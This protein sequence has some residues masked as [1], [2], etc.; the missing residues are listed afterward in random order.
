MK[1]SLETLQ[2]LQKA[3]DSAKDEL[4]NARNTR[5][6]AKAE[7]RKNNSRANRKTAGKAQIALD[8]AQKQYEDAADKVAAEVGRVAASEIQDYSFPHKKRTL[9][10]AKVR[11]AKVRKA[12]RHPAP[13]KEPIIPA[14]AME[15]FGNFDW[16]THKNRVRQQKAAERAHE[17]REMFEA[18][19]KAFEPK[20]TDDEQYIIDLCW[21][22]IEA[23]NDNAYAVLRDVIKKDVTPDNA[24]PADVDPGLYK[25]E[26]K[27]IAKIEKQLDELNYRYERVAARLKKAEEQEVISKKKAAV[28]KGLA[29]KALR[30][31]MAATA[32][33]K[34]AAYV[35]M[36]ERKREAE[37]A[38][39]T[40]EKWLNEL[41]DARKTEVAC[42]DWYIAK[43]E[44]LKEQLEH[45][46][47]LLEIAK[48]ARAHQ[49]RQEALEEAFCQR[50]ERAEYVPEKEEASRYKMYS[51]PPKCLFDEEIAIIDEMWKLVEEH[52]AGW[53]QMGKMLYN[54][55][56]ALIKSKSGKFSVDVRNCTINN[57]SASQ[58]SDLMGVEYGAKVPCREMVKL[59]YDVANVFRVFWKFMGNSQEEADHKLHNLR[60]YVLERL[61]KYGCELTDGAELFGIFDL[62]AANNTMQKQGCCHMGEHE[63]MKRTEQLREFGWVLKEA[64]EHRTDNASEW[65]KR[66]AI[67]TTP[68]KIIKIPTVDKDGNQAFR[69]TNVQRI[70]MVKN[71]DIERWCNNV[72]TIDG[73]ALTTAQ[74][75]KLKMT[76]FDGQAVWLVPNAPTTQGRGPALKY[77][78]VAMPDYKLPEFAIDIMGNKVRVAD[79]DILMTESCWKANKMGWNWYQ[80]RDKMTELAKECEGFD[81]LRAVRYSDREI[82]DEENPRNLARQATQQIVHL[83]EGEEVK[84]TARTRK[85]LKN[86]KKYWHI[87]AE[88]GEL[89]KPVNERSSLALLFNRFPELVMHP[90]I[91][92][93]LRNSWNAKKNKACSGRLRTKGVYPYICMDPIAQIQICLEGRDP[94]DKDLGVLPEGFVNLPKVKE[95]RKM[96]CLRYP[97]NYLVGMVVRQMNCPEFRGL[98]NIAVLPYYGDIIVRADGDFDGDEMLF[99]F[100]LLMI[101]MMERTIEEFKPC[102]IDF[103]HGKVACDTPFGTEE[104]FA[105]EIAEALVRAQEFNLVGRYSNLAVICLQQASL[106]TDPLVKAKWLN[107]AK[108]AHVGAIVC[109]DMV[110]G[111]DVPEEL[112]NLLANLNKKIRAM[113]KMPWN[114]I[115]SH[116]E[117][118]EEDVEPRT[119]ST[120]DRIAGCICDDVGEFFVDFEDDAPVTCGDDI[121]MALVP[122]G[123]DI[124]SVKRFVVDDEDLARIRGCHFEDGVDMA[125]W[126]KLTNGEPIGWKEW[127]ELGWHNASSLLWKMKGADMSEKRKELYAYV[128][129]VLM[130][131]VTENVWLNKDGRECTLVEKY[132]SLITA[133]VESAFEYRVKDGKVVTEYLDKNGT[134]RKYGNNIA[135]DMKGSYAMFILRVFAKDILALVDMGVI[136][137]EAVRSMCYVNED[138]DDRM[139]AFWDEVDDYVVEP[140]MCFS[141]YDEEDEDVDYDSLEAAFFNNIA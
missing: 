99:L 94:Y 111:A 16:A 34:T 32:E 56:V 51:I 114:Q 39:K 63:T 115:F 62:L 81:L 66:N 101:E 61:V 58:M 141:A 24:T 138:G 87:V 23:G 108:I 30:A 136:S 127:V 88:L 55:L 97:A 22:Q 28:R 59:T 71:V 128:R 31:Y 21:E 36:I 100:D 95:G 140:S 78:A 131:N 27:D 8:E 9:N 15:A 117:L 68:S 85:W 132:C 112:K 47:N 109:L 86:H 90:H 119:N 135:E 17:K 67:L 42:I 54:K 116:P 124:T 72:T 75:K 4:M 120:Q 57:V 53:V 105:Y 1:K 133:V 40:H 77:M 37:R 130:K 19:K 50:Y 137:E 84:L 107:A 106:A 11:K 98:G 52:P 60:A 89:D 13:A 10:K 2:K 18:V 41:E 79:Y 44:Q 91:Q 126:A 69:T 29:T 49:R 35:A 73:K 103:P 96:Y 26:K 5:N 7:A 93:Y 104:N 20:Y 64:I 102:L 139:D 25:S 33:E 121:L 122:F 92:Q 113:F 12:K 48:K 134:L 14:D 45:A 43:E 82:G 3:L 74:K 129:R 46:K 123:V 70:L 38:I 110:K 6:T 125:V 76:M 65:L 80:F 83:L 118:T